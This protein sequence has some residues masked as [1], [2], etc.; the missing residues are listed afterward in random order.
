MF[1]RLDSQTP[2][3]PPFHSH[4]HTKNPFQWNLKSHKYKSKLSQITRT[5]NLFIFFAA[6][7]QVRAA[8]HARSAWVKMRQHQ[9]EKYFHFLSFALISFASRMCTTVKTMCVSMG[10]SPLPLKS[11]VS[12]TQCFLLSE[13]R[14]CSSAHT[15]THTQILSHRN[16]IAISCVFAGKRITFLVKPS[17]KVCAR[18]KLL[19]QNAIRNRIWAAI[20]F[21]NTIR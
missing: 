10:F 19:C 13:T 6:V 15:L 14:I 20:S 11:D 18:R 21:V 4:P 2:P 12:C 16:S 9:N 1:N 8:C 3:S 5:D 7:Y 17:C